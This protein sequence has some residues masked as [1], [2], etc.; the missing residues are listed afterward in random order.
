MKAVSVL[1]HG[2]HTMNELTAQEFKL[3]SAA[4]MKIIRRAARQEYVTGSCMSNVEVLRAYSVPSLSQQLCALKLSYWPRVA[5]YDSPIFRTCL[6]L[7][8]G[9]ASKARG[10][11]SSSWPLLAARLHGHLGVTTSP[12]YG[13]C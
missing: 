6:S 4:Y 5:R 10:G 1:T 3:L 8:L 13:L 9:E 11:N 12:F 7:D 2:F